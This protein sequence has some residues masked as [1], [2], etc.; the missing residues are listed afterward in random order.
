MS[1]ELQNLQR[2]AVTEE[3]TGSF[4]IDVTAS[5]TYRDV[6]IQEGSLQVTLNKPAL[7]PNT[8]QQ[9]IDALAQHVYGPRSATMSFTCVLGATGVAAGDGDSPPNFAAAAL[10]QILRTTFGGAF[11]AGAG[12]DVS[13][14]TDANK[15][16]ATS[17]TAFDD[18]GVIG[19]P[20]S[21]GQIHAHEIQAVAADITTKID[22]PATPDV[23]DVLYA[24]MTIYPTND[25]DKSLQFILEGAE[26]DDRWLLMGGQLSSAPAISR[27]LGE[28]PTITFNFTFADW[29]L[30]PSAA[31]TAAAYGTFSPTHVHGYFR[32][33]AASITLSA[34]ALLCP[35]TVEYSL[36]S[37]VFGPV[38]CGS[39]VNTIK[40]WR[41]V[42]AV[43]FVEV[44]ITVPYE[45][46]TWFTARD[47]R[48]IYHLE[49]QMGTTAGG[50]VL[51]TVPAAYV[52][53]VQRVEQAGLAYQR[54]TFR[55]TI[56]A[57][58][59]TST[60]ELAVAAMRIHFL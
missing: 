13:S 5:A 52:V 6:P 59:Q 21:A 55:S 18:G 30:E 16:D 22:L 36:S 35:A 41:R 53:D 28:L 56:D 19:W 1:I 9:N 24:G 20:D 32:A 45:D 57:Y 47:N 12:T 54:I 42:R 29:A 7:D 31:I 50:I 11:S 23:A 38:M 17:L 34:R 26:A 10:T 15:F 3:A 48:T 33:K 60:D 43:P 8:V 49:D 2:L 4:A 37:P 39:G 44:S 58:V 40:R 25:P 14:V 27:T 46:Q 51:I